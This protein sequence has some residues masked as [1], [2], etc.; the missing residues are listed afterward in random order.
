MLP[1]LRLRG[2]A[3]PLTTR[4]LEQP[5]RGAACN[6]RLPTIVS[7]WSVV[8]PRPCSH[9]GKN[10]PKVRFLRF[11]FWNCGGFPVH[12]GDPKDHEICQA[13][14]QQQFDVIGLAETNIARHLVPPNQRLRERTWDWFKKISISSSYAFK[15]P[16]VNP[17]LV[18]GT[19]TL[20]INDCVHR[21][22]SMEGDPS[23]MGCWASVKLQGKDQ[24]SVRF[25]SAYRCVKNIHGP[26]SVWNQ[27]RF[28]LDSNNQTDDPLEAF[29][30]DLINNIK[31]WLDLGEQ[32]I[33]GID[34]NEDVRSGTFAQR[35][36]SECGLQ[37]IM[38]KNLGHNLPNTYARGSIP[39]EG[40]F[41]SHSLATCN[42]GYS[43]IICDHRM[44]WIEV[45]TEIAIGYKPSVMLALTPKCLILQ[46]P[47]IVKKY[48]KILKTQL[49]KHDVLNR[50]QS[51]E[52]SITG[53]LSSAQIKEYGRL[54]KIR[55]QAA[56]E[57]QRRCRKLRMGAVPY[58]PALSLAE[59]K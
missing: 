50:I 58:S 3:A 4:T 46:D 29:D 35:L 49:E 51:L 38:I 27:Q 25:I 47:R 31:K 23:G 20:T 14:L 21:V 15:F 7:G 30:Q 43:E 52:A 16:A 9:P 18:G 5:L 41:V 57:A 24:I 39:I 17:L 6:D 42:S 28:I 48:N 1:F 59:K 32:V 34:A 13:L 12:A 55:I 54:D 37:K 40:L 2:L 11:G 22:T 26:L 10:P 8:G 44:L 53:K 19:A 45:P 56:T 33:L 36:R